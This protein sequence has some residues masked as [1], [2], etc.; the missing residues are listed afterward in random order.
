V[1]LVPEEVLLEHRHTGDHT[2]VAAR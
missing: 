1:A 2:G